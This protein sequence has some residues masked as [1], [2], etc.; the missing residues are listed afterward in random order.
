MSN[1]V[2]KENIDYYET[3]KQTKHVSFTP[4]DVEC[5]LGG[6][7]GVTLAVST[8]AIVGVSHMKEETRHKE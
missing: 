1:A 3:N 8:E 5:F 7:L 6:A 2:T 4:D